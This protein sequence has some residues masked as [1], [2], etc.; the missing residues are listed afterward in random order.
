[1]PQEINREVKKEEKENKQTKN[2][3]KNKKREGHNMAS[4]K[5]EEHQS[6]ASLK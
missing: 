4:S 2:T 1:M 5:A 3:K 6:E